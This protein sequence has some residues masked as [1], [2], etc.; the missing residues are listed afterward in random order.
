VDPV[1][2]R[3]H[4]AENRPAGRLQGRQVGVAGTEFHHL[5]RNDAWFGG[6]AAK[7]K[8]ISGAMVPSGRQPR[9]PARTRRDVR[10]SYELP[11]QGF[12]SRLQIAGQTQHRS[13]RPFSTWASSILGMNVT[14]HRFDNLKVTAVRVA[15]ALALSED[16]R[17]GAVRSWASRCSRS[18][19]LADG[20]LPWPQP[21][22][23]QHR[24]SAKAKALMAEAGY[25]NGFETT[26]SFDLGFATVNEPTGGADPG[27]PRARSASRPRFNK[28]PGSNFRT[29][30]NIRRFLPLYLNVFSGWLDYPE[31]FF[32]WVLS[33]QEFDLQH[34]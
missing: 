13:T 33:R 3:I 27:K 28:I 34:Q 31:Y 29:E 7:V 1:G 24:T 10:H 8:K 26:L 4:Q 6:P 19:R 23:F 9:A 21:H 32:I 14:K 16:H 25:P 5:E 18:R 11:E 20:K 22:H 17:R 30:L 2:P 15:Y 12:G